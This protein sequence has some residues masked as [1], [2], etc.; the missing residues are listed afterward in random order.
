MRL[1]RTA[2]VLNDMKA[3]ARDGKV[4]DVVLR[5]A[6]CVKTLT[7]HR[8]GGAFRRASYGDTWNA[9]VLIHLRCG[10]TKVSICLEF[11]W[12]MMCAKL[13]IT[14]VCLTRRPMK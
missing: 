8:G 5:H 3:Y 14:G 13:G 4:D 6:S 11:V 10:S 12:R 1:L 9:A 7:A 2:C